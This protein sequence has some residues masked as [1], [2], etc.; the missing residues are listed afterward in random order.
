MLI[1]SLAQTLS[2]GILEA[3]TVTFVTVCAVTWKLP[4]FCHNWLNSATKRQHLAYIGLHTKVENKFS[5]NQWEH[6]VLISRNLAVFACLFV[7]SACSGGSDTSF[8]APPV[9][10]AA[11]VVNAGLDVTI[12]LPADN[13]ALDGTVSDDGQPA[14]AALSTAWSVQSGPAGAVFA[15]VN[16]VDTTVTFVSDG[17]YVLELIADDTAL[18]GGDTVTIT[19][20]AAPA[21]AVITVTPSDAALLTG[22]CLLAAPRHS[23]PAVQTNTVIRSPRL[24]PGRQPGAR[25]MRPE[26]TLLAA[27]PVHSP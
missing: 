17:T 23:P 18:Q 19:V 21:L 6:P 9:V 24:P 7:L 3:N 5:L 12:R 27:Q 1:G 10:N 11:P 15:D 26:I 25:L 14:G 8:T 16:V 22:R 2:W 13:V 20:E 4:I